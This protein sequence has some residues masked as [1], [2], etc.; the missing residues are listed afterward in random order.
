MPELYNNVFNTM[1]HERRISMVELRDKIGRMLTFVDKKNKWVCV[2]CVLNF[3]NML[4]NKSLAAF[5]NQMMHEDWFGGSSYEHFSADTLTE[6]SGYFTDTLFTFWNEDDYLR[7]KKGRWSDSLCM[8][9]KDV[10][11]K[12]DEAF[13][14]VV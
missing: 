9:F 12:M 4:K 5:A 8:K 13:R 1:L 7:K 3:H 2:W 10:C 11:R 14:A 6:Y